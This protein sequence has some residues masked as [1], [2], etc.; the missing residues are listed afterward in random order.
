MECIY[1][2]VFKAFFLSYQS[3]GLSQDMNDKPQKTYDRQIQKII[4]ISYVVIYIIII[5]FLKP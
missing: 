2:D 4:L 1:F 5:K 3:L